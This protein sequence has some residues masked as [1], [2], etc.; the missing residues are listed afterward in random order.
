MLRQKESAINKPCVYLIPAFDMKPREIA[1]FKLQ[2]FNVVPLTLPILRSYS[3]FEEVLDSIKRQIPEAHPRILGLCSGGTLALHPTLSGSASKVVAVSCAASRS[4]VPVS[5]QI[6]AL[7]FLFAPMFPLKIFGKAFNYIFESLMH[8]RIH[9][10]RIWLK[11]EQNKFIVRTIMS[12]QELL[13]S[14]FFVRIHGEHD[15]IFPLGK[16]IHPVVI[17]GGGHFLIKKHR[18]RLLTEIELQFLQ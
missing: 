10:S 2:E 8:T 17:K 13:V 7:A 16:I 9:F 14:D 18:K 12:T 4:E 1:L 3:T 15:R 6:L 5:H 11:F